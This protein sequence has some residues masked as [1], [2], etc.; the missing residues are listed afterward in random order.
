MDQNIDRMVAERFIPAEIPVE[1]QGHAR[2]G[3]CLP[4][5]LHECMHGLEQRVP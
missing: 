3:A 4:G 5:A 1:R 2:K